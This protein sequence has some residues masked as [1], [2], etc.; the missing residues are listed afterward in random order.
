MAKSLDLPLVEQIRGKRLSALLAR[1]DEHGEEA[2][3]NV[4]AAVPNS[5][6]WRGE[7]GWRGNFDSLMRPDN[8]QR[9]KEGAYAASQRAPPAK[10]KYVSKTGYEYRGTEEQVMREAQRRGDN[11]TYW[12]VQV[13]MRRRREATSIGD[14]VKGATA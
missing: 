3:S 2:V 9:M 11:D 6:H 10:P 8:F 14:L 12:Q 13:D 5:P 4:I 7:N 1:I